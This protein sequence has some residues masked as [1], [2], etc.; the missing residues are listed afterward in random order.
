MDL[1]NYPNSYY[2]PTILTFFD[3]EPS[4]LKY[5]DQAKKEI[6]FFCCTGV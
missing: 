1:S 2:I 3:K 6:K 4:P 5:Q